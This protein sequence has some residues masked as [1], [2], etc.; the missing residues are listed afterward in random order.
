MSEISESKDEK[1]SRWAHMLNSPITSLH[2]NLHLLADGTVG[3]LSE[4][5]QELVEDSL[6]NSQ[7]LVENIQKLLNELDKELK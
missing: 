7:R 4:T 6:Q 3:E 5:Q 1:F 2:M